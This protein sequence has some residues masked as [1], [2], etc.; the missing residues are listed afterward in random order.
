MGRLT[1]QTSVCFAQHA[2]LSKLPAHPPQS[3]LVY[4]AQL[5]MLLPPQKRD[6]LESMLITDLRGDLPSGPEATSLEA[7]LLLDALKGLAAHCSKF[8]ITF[9]NLTVRL[10]LYAMSSLEETATDGGVVRRESV[11]SQFF[12]GPPATG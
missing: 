12:K 10:G 9:V 11:H 1:S 5:Q 6:S 8:A 3:A 2:C 7:L 4:L